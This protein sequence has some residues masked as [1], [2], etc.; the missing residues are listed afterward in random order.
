[1]QVKTLR[2]KVRHALKANQLT[3]GEKQYCTEFLRWESPTNGMV[4]LVTKVVR[5]RERNDK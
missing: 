2:K 4:T 1:M 5:H 3:N